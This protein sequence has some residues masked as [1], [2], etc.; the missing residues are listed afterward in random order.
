MSDRRR[1]DREGIITEEKELKSWEVIG[2]AS[3]C[4]AD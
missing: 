4:L 1:R 2:V 3:A